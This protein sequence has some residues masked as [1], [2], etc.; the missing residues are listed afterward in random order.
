MDRTA[1]TTL[2]DP[3]RIPPRPPRS[4]GQHLTGVGRVSTRPPLPMRPTPHERDGRQPTPQPARP[5]PAHQGA[6]G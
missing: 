3:A 2:D 6:T 1:L 5:H 4:G